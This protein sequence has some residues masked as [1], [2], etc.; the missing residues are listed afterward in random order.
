MRTTLTSAGYLD[1]SNPDHILRSF[2]RIFGKN[3][4]TERDVRILRGLWRRIDWLN[5]QLDTVLH[6]SENSG[7]DS[8]V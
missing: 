1:E 8:D 7:R 5:A 3:G 2:R 6:E 4:L